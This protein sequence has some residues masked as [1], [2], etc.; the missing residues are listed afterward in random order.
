MNEVCPMCKLEISS[1]NGST[2][3]RSCDKCGSNYVFIC[4]KCIDKF[5]EYL[6]YDCDY[7]KCLKCGK[8]PCKMNSNVIKNLFKD[9]TLKDYTKNTDTTT[10]GRLYKFYKSTY[11]FTDDDI[12]SYM[13]Y[14]INDNVLNILYDKLL[15]DITN[16]LDAN[17]HGVLFDTNTESDYSISNVNL[18]KYL[19]P[20]NYTIDF[21]TVYEVINNV[22]LP[23]F[24]NLYYDLK[25][26]NIDYKI[27]HTMVV[28]FYQY[29]LTLKST[30]QQIINKFENANLDKKD[31]DE[32]KRIYKNNI[33]YDKNYSIERYFKYSIPKDKR[34]KYLNDNNGYLNDDITY[35]SPNYKY[36]Y[37]GEN[38]R[39][40][41]REYLVEKK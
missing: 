4:G 11:G 37:D 33:V 34:I 12:Y 32:F 14:L 2:P 22:F 27:Y 20:E 28:R 9:K 16:N 26:K 18:T 30:K 36:K 31:F 3:I 10:F 5:K 19:D 6:Y 8:T 23:Y 35:T 7:Y 38:L 39:Y 1:D 29:L 21:Y 25:R 40:A 17:I 24:V 15:F 13:F 41:V